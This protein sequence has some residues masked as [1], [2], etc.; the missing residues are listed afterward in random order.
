MSF[1]LSKKK[2]SEINLRHLHSVDKFYRMHAGVGS[3]LLS[4]EKDTLT[5]EIDVNDKWLTKKTL[6]QTSIQFLK[7]WKDFNKELQKYNYYIV[8]IY[9]SSPL[10]FT[11]DIKTPKEDIALKLKKLNSKKVKILLDVFSNREP[12]NLLRRN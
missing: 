7:S 2:V 5:L 11:I 8:N 1:N 4:V 9:K 6:E 12:N 3:K 10:G